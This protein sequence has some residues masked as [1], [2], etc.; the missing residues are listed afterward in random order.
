MPIKI[1]DLK[2]GYIYKTKGKTYSL[3]IGLVSTQSLKF[4]RLSKHILPGNDEDFLVDANIIC[5]TK[6]YK[7][8]MQFWHP[9]NFKIVTKYIEYG[10]LWLELTDEAHYL[11][12]H[13]EPNS[14]ESLEAVQSYIGRVLDGGA[15]GKPDA[16]K[17]AFR[18]KILFTEVVFDKCFEFDNGEVISKVRQA[19]SEYNLLTSFLSENHSWSDIRQRLFR[20]FYVDDKYHMFANMTYFG[21]Y[22]HINVIYEDLKPYFISKNTMA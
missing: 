21:C 1:E 14:I 2:P 9:N 8:E 5:G 7:H 16:S 19:V 6:R 11:F 4:A 13:P 18:E 17:F 12:S 20:A 15:R 10:T 22:P 3:F